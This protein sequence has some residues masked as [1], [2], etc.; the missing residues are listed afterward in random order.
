MATYRAKINDSEAA[1][2]GTVHFDCWIQRLESEDPDV[3]INVENGH[4]TVVLQAASIL[5]I[6]DNDSL[7]DTQKRDQLKE[8]F[9]LQALSWGIDEAD[10]ANEDIVLLIPSESWPVNVVL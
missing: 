9:R 1:G 7:T 5:F 3:W 10:N 6:T 2:N 4:R 8:L